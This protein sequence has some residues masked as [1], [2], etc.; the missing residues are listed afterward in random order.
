MKTIMISTSDC[1]PHKNSNHT[2]SGLCL[3]ISGINRYFSKE[4]TFCLFNLQRFKYLLIFFSNNY[5]VTTGV[6]LCW[7]LDTRENPDIALALL[8][9][10]MYGCKDEM[11]WDR[12]FH[13]LPLV[14]L[15][16]NTTF[17]ENTLTTCDKSLKR[18]APSNSTFRSLS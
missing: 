2:F 12:H 8:E 10:S 3:Y 17:L 11:Q 7:F 13:M 5:W 1:K 15:Q 9:I 4:W 6:Y 18:D 14:E 16:L